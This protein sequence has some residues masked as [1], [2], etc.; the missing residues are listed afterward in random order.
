[1]DASKPTFYLDQSTFSDAFR[2][3]AAPDGKLEPYR[4]LKPWIERV[5]REANLCLSN[6]HIAE[7]SRWKRAATRDAMVAWLDAL[8]T[9]WVRS[10]LDVR[11]E[12]AEHWT[13]IAAGRSPRKIEPFTDSLLA[14]FRYTNSDVAA[15]TASEPGSIRPFVEAAI[16]YGFPDV[17][18][19][20]L[21]MFRRLRDNAAWV[22]QAGW[23]KEQKKADLARNVRKS[24]REEAEAAINAINARSRE[25]PI[26]QN[27]QDA[28]VALVE[29]EP[30]AMPAWRI[31][32]V[33]SG[34]LANLAR[35]RQAGS[36]GEKELFSSFYDHQHLA[37]PGAYCDVF[38]CDRL[39]QNAIGHA[40]ISLGLGAALAPGKHAGGA[41]GFVAALTAKWP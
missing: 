8:P 23:S 15:A 35:E 17:E 34:Y 40:R 39:V 41:A 38:T 11:P 19:E 16:E 7:V 2:A 28:L 36:K 1:V 12:E 20:M 10:M 9:V 3:H 13:Q 37:V 30:R 5:A 22:K 25:P 32:T 6:T 27:V 29:K 31:V 21:A 14:A 4:P 33:F 18:R 24:L 26:S